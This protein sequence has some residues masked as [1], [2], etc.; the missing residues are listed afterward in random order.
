ML[1]AE[2][3]AQRILQ[4]NS[5]WA[6]HEK[7]KFRISHIFGQTSL[8]ISKLYWQSKCILPPF[9]QYH[10][11]V[12]WST[13]SKHLPNQE[14]WEQGAQAHIHAA[15]GHHQWVLWAAFASAP[16]PTQH[17]S[18]SQCWE[19][20]SCILICPFPLVLPLSTT[21]KNLSLS[22]LHPPFRYL[23]TLMRSPESLLQADLS[24]VS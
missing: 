5:F 19:R 6:L 24:Q 8:A 9:S 16:S 14:H 11:K 1:I 10:Q 22:S 17:R 4:Y 7:T 15:F 3:I 2:L 18:A 12:I 21:E 13:C 20:N 23:W